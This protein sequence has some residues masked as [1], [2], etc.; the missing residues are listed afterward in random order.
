MFNL[1]YWAFGSRKDWSKNEVFQSNGHYILISPSGWNF[2]WL[3]GDFECWPFTYLHVSNSH[4]L[5]KFQTISIV[6][7]MH[8]A[9]RLLPWKERITYRSYCGQLI[10]LFGSRKHSFVS[11]EN[12]G[13]SGH[14][15]PV[16]LFARPVHLFLAAVVS[17]SQ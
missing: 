8:V 1:D 6:L 15:W 10:D 3:K 11:N 9:L 17:I 16:F 14:F 5:H 12:I 4:T 2:T 7:I 13:L